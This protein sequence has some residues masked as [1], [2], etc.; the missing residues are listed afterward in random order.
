MLLLFPYCDSSEISS[1][2]ELAAE[3]PIAKVSDSTKDKGCS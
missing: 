2:Q 1:S 3:L